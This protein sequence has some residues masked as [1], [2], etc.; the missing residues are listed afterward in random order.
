MLVR[1]QHIFGYTQNY[2]LNQSPSIIAKIKMPTI[3]KNK[4]KYCLAFNL[5][6][7]IILDNNNETTHTDDIIGAA[8]APF[9]LMAYTYVN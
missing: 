6:F 5:S 3:T 7:R 8:I 2:S 9:P 4:K 1:E